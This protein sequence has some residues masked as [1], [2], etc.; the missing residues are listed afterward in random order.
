MLTNGRKR[1]VIINVAPQVENGAYPAKTT[2]GEPT[3][4]S[5]DIFC[6]GHDEIAA[7]I[8]L[9]HKTERVWKEFPIQLVNNDHWELI[10]KLAKTGY[11]QF[12]V[13]AW[14]DHFATWRKGLIKKMDAGQDIT[15]ELQIGSELLKKAAVQAK[16]KEKA[17]LQKYADD[18]LQKKDN[19]VIIF[20]GDNKLDVVLRTVRNKEFVTG[21]AVYQIEAER[22]KAAFSTWYELFPRSAAAEPG[23]HGTLA[24]V[25]RLLPRIARMGFDTIYFPPIH[26]VGHVKRKGRNNSLTAQPDD[27]GSPWAIGSK[28]GGHKSIHPELGNF[29]DLQRLVREAAKYNIEIAMDIAFQCAPDHPYVKLHPQWFKWRPDGTV[30]YAEN[31]PKKYED[32]LPFNF[33]TEDWENL[34]NELKSVIEFWISKGIKIFRVDNPHTKALPFWEWA[35]GEIRKE[36]PETIFLAEAFTRPRIMEWL[37][38]TGFNQSYTYFTWRITKQELEEYL[39]ELTTTEKQYYFRPN[40][41]P[42]TPDIL[43]PH[44]TYGGENAHIIRLILAATMSS[45]YGLYGPVYEFGL[46]TPMPAKEEYIDNEKYEI[47]YWRWEEETRIQEIITRVNK[48]RRENIAFHTTWNIEFAETTNDHIICYCKADTETGNIFIIAVN[49]DPYNTQTANVKIPLQSLGIRSEQPY[50]VSDLLSG[51]RYQWREEWNYV[52][53]NPCEMPAHILK[54]EQ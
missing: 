47:R 9:K 37:A 53:L 26:P 5:V 6:D 35:I 21:S 44:L 51:D 31:P 22:K 41:W 42:N 1:V 45:N 4:F 48:I 14:I 33:E 8:L 11:Y 29:K 15:L 27:P 25:E 43:P 23:K 32:I 54:V 10:L 30:Q 18:L 12:Q 49:L 36:H 17:V 13:F 38:K 40:F 16:A 2:V 28:D 39:T 24:D 19:E 7:V 20:L 3:V 50:T 34:W 46:N 52:Q